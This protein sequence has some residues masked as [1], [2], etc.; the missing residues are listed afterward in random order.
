MLYNQAREN[1]NSKKGQS[2]SVTFYQNT[3]SFSFDICLHAFE[4]VLQ[5]LDNPGTQE[6]VLIAMATCVLAPCLLLSLPKGN[7]GN[8]L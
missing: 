1:C 2:I 3:F 4:F 6:T 8:S 7:F 5:C